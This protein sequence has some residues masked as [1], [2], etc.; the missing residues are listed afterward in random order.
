M[1]PQGH[2]VL[3][4]RLDRRVI[5][6]LERRVEEAHLAAA[7]AHHAK[8]AM[9]DRRPQFAADVDALEQ[10]LRRRAVQRHLQQ[11]V[12]RTAVILHQ[13]GVG[14]P[15]EPL[16]LELIQRRRLAEQHALPL[17]A[18]QQG[19]G[20]GREVVVGPRDD[21]ALIVRDPVVAAALAVADHL[22]VAG[23]QIDPEQGERH[24]RTQAHGPAAEVAIPVAVGL[25]RAVVAV[26]LPL[27]LARIGED[28]DAVAGPHVH[29]YDAHDLVG[30]HL[31]PVRQ[32]HGLADEDQQVVVPGPRQLTHLHVAQAGRVDHSATGG[33]DEQPPR[34]ALHI[35]EGEALAI[36]RQDH[37][38]DGRQGP[39]GLERWLGLRGSG[40]AQTCKDGGAR[41]DCFEHVFPPCEL[42]PRSQ[43][44]VKLTE[45]R[46]CAAFGR[47]A[48]Q[49]A[50]ATLQPGSQGR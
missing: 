32:V 16:R 6:G 30:R 2:V 36:G 13:H 3:G 29:A 47:S 1:G 27:G 46:G 34:L 9:G 5:A 20:I 24:G 25:A 15:P 38:L 21:L 23:V 42:N 14:R 11:H 33:A 35:D 7:R 18:R 39:V 19:P 12:L 8:Q 31:H 50:L 26:H 37:V 49:G 43:G 10:P 22:H 45:R 17:G 40:H 28:P 48:P 41:R 44:R 4:E